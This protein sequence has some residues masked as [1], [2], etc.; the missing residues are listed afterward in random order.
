M[1]V[2][3]YPVALG[4]L[5][6]LRPVF[7]ERRRTWFLA[8]EVAMLLISLGWLLLGRAIGPIINGAAL[9]AFAVAWV[10]TGRGNVAIRD[11]TG[12]GS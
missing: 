1:L 11:G 10:R 9:V 12:P 5:A 2:L 6:R 8:L 4:V 3:G 7:R